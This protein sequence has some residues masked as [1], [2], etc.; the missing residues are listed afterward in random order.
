MVDLHAT[1]VALRRLR[2]GDVYH[3]VGGQRGQERGVG[4]GRRR[5]AG[6]AR[7]RDVRVWRRELLQRLMV[8]QVVLLLLLLMVLLLLL[9]PRR[10][11]E[12]LRPAADAARA[13]GRAEY[14]V[15][16]VAVPEAVD[17][18]E[19]EGLGGVGGVATPA[20]RLERLPQ[21]RIQPEAQSCIKRVMFDL[22]N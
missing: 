4:G 6:G 2:R 10:R 13:V 20:Q 14:G 17:V 22:R 11:V 8:M 5:V 9:P 19:R 12:R 16:S 15:D 7:H 21:E 1:V 3:V 18:R